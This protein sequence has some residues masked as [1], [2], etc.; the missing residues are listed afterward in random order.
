MIE[1]TAA[2]QTTKADK[3]ILGFCKRW[4]DRMDVNFRER[5]GVIHF[6]N[7]VAT[8]TPRVDQLIV[9]ILANDTPSIERV[10]NVVV[11][12]LQDALARDE[13]R[14]DWRWSSNLELHAL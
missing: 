12:H 1:A 6:E 14:F 11:G 13:L 8:L 9:T 4:Q 10:Q 2:V 5:Q 7:A 3:F